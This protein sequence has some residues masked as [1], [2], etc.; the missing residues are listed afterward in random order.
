MPPPK[1]H[2]SE[3]SHHGSTGCGHDSHALVDHLIS[4]TTYERVAQ[5]T[6]CAGFIAATGK[7]YKMRRICRH[8]SHTTEC[9]HM[10]SIFYLLP[11]PEMKP[12]QKVVCARSVKATARQ[13][14]WPSL[15]GAPEAMLMVDT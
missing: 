9:R 15:A 14:C 5:T 1:R 10:R 13:P 3:L 8:S 4:P 6:D 7:R 12:T 11:V 2:G